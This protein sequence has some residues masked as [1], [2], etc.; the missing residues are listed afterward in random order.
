MTTERIPHLPPQTGNLDAMLDALASQGWYEWPQALS[1][2]LC[3]QLLA[4]SQ[5]YAQTDQ[6]TPAGIGRGTVHQRNADIRRDKIRWLDGQSLAQTQ[7]LAQMAQIQ[8]QLNQAFYLGLFEYEAH[9]A[10]Y[11]QGDFYKKHLD[12]FKGRANRMV[13]TVI[14]LNPDWQAE[15]GGELVIWPRVSDLTDAANE[16]PASAR[17]DQ[18]LARILPEMGKMVVFLS[19][20]FPHEV[21]PTQQPRVSIAGWFRCNTSL[22]GVVDPAH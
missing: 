4:E 15:W 10:R 2:K 22:G 19:E 8:T 20:D 16:P 12:S 7:F 13:T 17:L 21:L 14:Y 18:P 3:Q 9:F 1:A 11:E 5:S 6:L